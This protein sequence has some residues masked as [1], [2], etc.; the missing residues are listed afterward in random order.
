MYDEQVVANAAIKVA[1]S[2]DYSKAFTAFL[3]THH[4]LEKYFTFA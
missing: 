3:E 2:V 4:F 1:I